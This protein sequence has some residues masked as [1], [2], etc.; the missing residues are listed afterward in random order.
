[1]QQKHILVFAALALLA[2]C[3]RMEAPP[4]TEEAGGGRLVSTAPNLTEIV[5][6]IGAGELLVGRTDVCDY[7]P[8]VKRV[9][10]VGGF[11]MPHLEPLLAA[12]PTHVLES[13]FADPSVKSHLDALGIPTVH[14]P[15]SRLDDIPRAIRQIGALTGR[16]KEAEVLAE[17]IEKVIGIEI[18]R[19]PDD[20]RVLLLFAPD[21]TIT[22]GGDTFVS[23]LVYLWGGLNVAAGTGKG[24]FH[25]SLEWVVDQDPDIILCLFD[26]Q[27]KDPASL[28]A[29]RTGWKDLKA[30]RGG[31]VRTVANLDT[32]LRPGPRVL[33]GL[34]Q[35][36]KLLVS[37]F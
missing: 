36:K 27:G 5:F 4:Q 30:V 31:G 28:F 9:P 17:R 21:S 6:A 16:E 12:R 7:P 33:E 2:G 35:L 3:K 19:G 32:V 14:V 8:E 23:E 26:T 1:M 15:C 22:A 10:V 29:S 13:A 11:G 25:V 18:H 24:Y 20:P 34:E 37:S